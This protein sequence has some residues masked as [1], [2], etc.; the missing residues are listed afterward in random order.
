MSYLF[1]HQ[2]IGSA[3]VGGDAEVGMLF[4]DGAKSADQ[5]VERVAGI[6]FAGPKCIA[7]LSLGQGVG[8]GGE[9][10]LHQLLLHGSEGYLVAGGSVEAMLGF[11]VG[12]TSVGVSSWIIVWC[13][14]I[15][16][17]KRNE[18]LG[19]RSRMYSTIAYHQG[20]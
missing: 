11:G 2:P 19:V 16:Q 17:W 5:G 3:A 7:D 13:E 12:Q 15:A 1:V 6:G 9:E 10:H 4:N 8:R 20:P 18:R 14:S